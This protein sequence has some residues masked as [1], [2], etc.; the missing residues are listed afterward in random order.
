MDRG[1]SANEGPRA[2]LLMSRESA[3]KRTTEDQKC[4]KDWCAD[5]E[6]HLRGT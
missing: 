3:T 4:A 2:T 6:N 5:L 1:Q